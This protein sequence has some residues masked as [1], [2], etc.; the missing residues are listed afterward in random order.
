M[1][2]LAEMLTKTVADHGE[3]IAIK[4]DDLELSYSL[5]DQASARAAACWPP[6]A[7]RQATAWE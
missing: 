7:S 3:R 4:L 6:R 1:A 2:N 5:I